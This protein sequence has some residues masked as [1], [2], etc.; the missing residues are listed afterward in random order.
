LNR[1]IGDFQVAKPS[2]KRS[3]ADSQLPRCF[4]SIA[5][6]LFQSAENKC[7]FGLVQI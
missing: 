1:W 3:A 7:L 2:M 6:A 4:G 5:A